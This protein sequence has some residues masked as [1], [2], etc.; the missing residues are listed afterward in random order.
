MYWLTGRQFDLSRN[1]MLTQCLCKAVGGGGRDSLGLNLDLNPNHICNTSLTFDL[2]SITLRNTGRPWWN[3]LGSTQHYAN[4]EHSQN[5][6]IIL[7]YKHGLLCNEIRVEKCSEIQIHPFTLQSKQ[8]KWLRKQPDT[9][10]IILI[11]VTASAFW[12]PCS[13]CRKSTIPKQE[14][15]LWSHTHYS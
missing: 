2:S 10:I 1:S 15:P 6:N 13:Q 12:C 3:A 4:M 9:P 8:A 11:R 14:T 5:N 7:W